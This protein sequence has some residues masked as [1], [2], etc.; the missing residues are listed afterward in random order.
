MSEENDDSRLTEAMGEVTALR[1]MQQSPGWKIFVDI[2]HENIHDR[3]QQIVLRPS[4]E[5]P[6]QEFMK[7]EATGMTTM[8]AFVDVKI[9]ECEA[10]IAA[11]KEPDDG[12]E[13]S[14]DS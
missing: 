9:D 11:L 8:L 7:G 3:T 13:E 5:V 2:V 10:L 1:A 4:S 12:E 6:D 14:G